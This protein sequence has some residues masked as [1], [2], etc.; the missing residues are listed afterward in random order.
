MNIET[1]RNRTEE[2]FPRLVE[3][4]CELIK[5]PSMSSPAFDQAPLAES[6]ERVAGLFKAEGLEVEICSVPGPDG[7]QGRPAI[8]AHKHVSDEAPTMLLYAHHD[9]QPGGDPTRWSTEGPFV[10]TIKGDRLY[11]RGASD[12][13]AGIMVHLGSLR[14]LAD[15]LGVNVTC[16]IEGE[17]ESGSPSFSNF[18][19]TYED[20]LQADVIV[21]CDS[22][23]WKVGEPALTTTLR[24]VNE[25]YCRV[26]VSEHAVHSGMF[27]GPVLDAPTLA[28]RLV[29][30]LHDEEGN[31]AVPDLGGTDECDVV[32]EE[33]D[34]REQVGLVDGYK[35]AGS[36]PLAARLWTKPA[37]ALIGMDV[38]SVAEHANVIHPECEFVLSLR[39]PP[40]V[41]GAECTQ[42]VV[43]YLYAN[44]PFGAEL[45]I[46]TG[47]PGPSYQADLDSEVTK[48]TLQSLSEAWGTE[49]VTVGTGGSIPFI[50]EF[51]Q[52]FPNA[53]VVVTGVEDP[54]TNAHSEDESQHLGDLKNAVLAQS[55]LMARLAGQL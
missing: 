26:K 14:V 53:D 7:W 23:N 21:V 32:Y 20:R 17:E 54:N 38:T 19:K 3:D 18:L 25:I 16:F 4:L 47:Q 28:C 36:G 43:D 55:I 24:G 37:L 34:L 2:Q 15:E 27:G 52:F 10:P 45:S 12:D 51:Q 5:I 50:S 6:A 44:A 29:A 22:D 31:I 11:G 8:L 13:G 35:L 30:T 42:K 46:R 9:V 39:I 1:L 48:Q 49:A 40:G 41:D 33:N